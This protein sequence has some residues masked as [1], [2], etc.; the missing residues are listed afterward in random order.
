MDWNLIIINI[1]NILY[2]PSL[3]N[4]F[5]EICSYMTM[6]AVCILCYGLGRIKKKVSISLF[7]KSYDYIIQF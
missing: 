2:T 6:F 5:S 1:D 7:Y 3:H 4:S